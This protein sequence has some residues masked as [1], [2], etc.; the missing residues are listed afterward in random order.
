MNKLL[1]IIT[2]ICLWT[3]MIP[4]VPE[5][6]GNLVYVISEDS[7][8]TK[9]EIAVK[10]KFE[11]YSELDE[12]GRCG[13]AYALITEDMM[14]A[15]GTT[16]GSLGMIT[17]SGWHTVR[18]DDLIED[19]YLYNR[20]HLIG[21]QLTGQTTNER[22]II[23]G[24]RF[25]NTHGMLPVEN[26][27]SAYIKTSHQPVLYKVTP[28][29]KGN[30][31]VASGV[32]IQACSVADDC[33]TISYNIYIYNIQPG[34]EIDYATGDSHK[35]EVTRSVIPVGFNLV[36]NTNT[37]KIHLPNCPSVDTIKEKNRKDVFGT[38]EEYEERGYT[39]CKQCLN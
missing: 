16:R 26:E 7:G 29:F 24:T 32:Q 14:P 23:T 9:E 2:I 33:K 36:L 35:I 22:N 25:F 28:D 21:F 5:Y 37:K 38:I 11:K 18:Y 17:P 27:I 31:L 13:P 6:D 20:C 10:D 12:L 4:I 34:I 15:D 39:R 1:S 3:G 8:F 19:Q 30:N